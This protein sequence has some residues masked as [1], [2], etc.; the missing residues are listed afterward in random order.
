MVV[1]MVVLMVVA[2][3]HQP[4]RAGEHGQMSANHAHSNGCLICLHW[5]FGWSVKGQVERPGRQK[6][7]PAEFQVSG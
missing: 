1:L 7:Q 6:Q 4:P 3:L 2:A 5:Q